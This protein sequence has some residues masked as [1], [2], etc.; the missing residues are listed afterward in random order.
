MNWDEIRKEYENSKIT[1]KD[2]A[3]KHNVKLGTLKSRKSREK[4]SRGA[5]KKDAT[6]AKRMQPKKGAPKGNKNAVGNRGN[7]NPIPKFAKRNTSAVTHGLFAKYI[8]PEQQEIIDSMQDMTIADQIWMQIEI[9]FSAI[10]RLQKIMRVEDEHDHLR[11][12]SGES[13]K[14][15]QGDSTT[16]KVIYAHERFESYINAQSRAM[17]E[18]RNLVKQFLDITDEFDERRLRLDA[19]Q[20]NID[21]N[22]AETKKIAK[23]DE[24]NDP[25]V[26]NIID[27]WGNGDG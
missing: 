27:A 9:K 24:G 5:T 13:K 8:H 2:L 10:I 7:P 4:W 16:Y 20:S 14:S 26:I 18:Y 12:I 21:R 22:K 23:E 11:E 6:E 25:P 17:A 15:F 3:A 19:M 1:L